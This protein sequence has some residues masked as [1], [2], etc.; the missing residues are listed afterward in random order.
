MKKVK[1][2]PSYFQG[3]LAG[4]VILASRFIIYLSHNWDFTIVPAYSLLTGL[5]VIVGIIM[6]VIADRKEFENAQSAELLMDYG[7]GSS[8][9]KGDAGS[10]GVR[11]NS[12]AEIIATK[13]ASTSLG[14]GAVLIEKKIFGFWLTFFSA[15]RVIA[16]A[17]FLV[18]IAD[19]TLMILIDSTL[20]DQ[21]KTLKIDQIKQSLMVFNVDNETIDLSIKQLREQDYTT[22]MF[23]LADWV[24]K[25]ISNAFVGLIVAAFMRRKPQTHW[26]DQ[27]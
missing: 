24:N 13:D 25:V 22:P 5:V 19:F 6:G 3:L 26:V 20:I 12:D 14:A 1:N 2:W 10:D 18:E 17:I 4:C 9:H 11:A 8:F 7:V 15:I 21:T 16:V 27:A 23:W